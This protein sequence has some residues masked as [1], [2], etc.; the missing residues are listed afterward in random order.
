MREP[1]HLRDNERAVPRGV[2]G[3]PVLPSVAA[4]G[5]HQRCVSFLARMPTRHQEDGPY[6]STRLVYQNLKV[7]LTVGDRFGG[8]RL[9]LRII[10]FKRNIPSPYF[11]FADDQAIIHVMVIA[12]NH[13]N[14][15]KKN[16]EYSPNL[17]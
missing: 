5:P 13:E 1:D 3:R 10:R 6:V 4:L 11:T 16:N 14:D 8:C 15:D 2:R 9:A 12:W 17:I 7:S